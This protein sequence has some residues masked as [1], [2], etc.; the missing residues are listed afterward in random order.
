MYEYKTIDKNITKQKPVA[1][2]KTHKYYLT[3]KQMKLHRCLTRKCTGLQRLSHE[4]WD[5]REERKRQKK[6][7]KIHEGLGIKLKE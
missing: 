6:I 7:R 4:F 5:E 1:Y 2:C 3:E